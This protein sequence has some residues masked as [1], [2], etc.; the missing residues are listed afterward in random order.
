VTDLRTCAGISWIPLPAD[1]PANLR[2]GVSTRRGGVSTGPFAAL[3]L[4]SRVGDTPTNVAWNLSRLSAACGADLRAAARIRLEHAAAA[5]VV[6]EPGRVGEGDALITL[7]P[8]LPLALTVA[9]CY[10]LALASPGGGVALAHCGWRGTLAGI[11]ETAAATLL[12]ATRARAQDLL[13]W[14]GPGIGPCCFGLPP[15]LAGRFHADA[16][17]CPAPSAESQG[18]I[19]VSI[20][21]EIVHRLIGLGLSAGQIRSAVGCTSCRSDLFY[22]YR[23]DRGETGRMLAWILRD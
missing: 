14:I 4:G 23:R 2:G 6:T 3:N 5:R 22:S 13:A 9:D 7:R 19:A 1:W 11:A 8:G 21:Q 10:P 17:G 20:A 16:R 18:A 15:A 12:T